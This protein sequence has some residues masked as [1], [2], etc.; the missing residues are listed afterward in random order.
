MWKRLATLLDMGQTLEGNGIKD[1]SGLFEKVGMNED[2][3][4]P[5]L[6]LY[7]R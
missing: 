3:H 6:H 2:E 1:E 4:L 5:A 7:F